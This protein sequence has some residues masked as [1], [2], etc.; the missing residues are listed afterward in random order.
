MLMAVLKVMLIQDLVWTQ[1][2]V[3]SSNQQMSSTNI[4]LHF[5]S[6]ESTYSNF[7]TQ[8]KHLHRFPT[9]YQQVSS[10][11]TLDEPT[12]QILRHRKLNTA[13]ARTGQNNENGV[14]SKKSLNC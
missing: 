6:T 9:S 10:K 3:I 13:Q 2:N 14:T 11:Q 12:K 8:L 7:Q 4:R 1:A 5:W